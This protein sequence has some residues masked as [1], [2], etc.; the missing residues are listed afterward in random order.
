MSKVGARIKW[1]KLKMEERYIEFREELR[2]ILGG[3]KE[4]AAN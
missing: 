2:K 1:W 3:R 4:L